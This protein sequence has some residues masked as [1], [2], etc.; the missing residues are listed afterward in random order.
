MLVV[1]SW[2]VSSFFLYQ[3]DCN[4]LAVA[5]EPRMEV[6]RQ[7]SCSYG[8][9]FIFSF[10]GVFL[11]VCVGHV[12]GSLSVSGLLPDGR[13]SLLTCSLFIV[14]LW[15]IRCQDADREVKED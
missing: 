7:S 2:R 10:A 4:R 13:W 6:L 14:N 15:W 5:E 12:R 8:Q 3:T 9:F 11:P 1:F